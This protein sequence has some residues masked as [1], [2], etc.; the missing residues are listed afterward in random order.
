M[1]KFYV[2]TSFTDDMGSMQ[3]FTVEGHDWEHAREEAL[4]HYN[5]ARDHDGLP[6]WDELPDHITLRR[7]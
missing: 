5:S 4:W 2:E 6:R 3:G 7:A 1:R